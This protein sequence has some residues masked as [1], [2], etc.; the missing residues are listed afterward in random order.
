MTLHEIADKLYAASNAARLAHIELM[1]EKQ[2]D[3]QHVDN[4]IGDA[5][6]LLGLARSEL[7]PATQ[8]EGDA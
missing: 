3:L 2:P 6:R 7:K 5:I 1:F 8:T 4:L